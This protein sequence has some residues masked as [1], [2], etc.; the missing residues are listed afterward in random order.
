MREISQRMSLEREQGK[1]EGI[2]R[3]AIGIK[4]IQGYSFHQGQLGKLPPMQ[5][6]EGNLVLGTPYQ[7]RRPGRALFIFLPLQQGSVGKDVEKRVSFCAGGGSVNSFSHSGK[8]YGGSL[9][10]ELPYDPA[11]PLL[12]YIYEGKENRVLRY[13]HS[14][15]RC[16]IAHNS[17]N[18]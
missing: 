5:T 6:P 9:K 4:I 7:V 3:F 1:L 10:L 17:Q 16:S 11:I 12:Q 14:H 8:H 18:I 15:V 2:S 13:L